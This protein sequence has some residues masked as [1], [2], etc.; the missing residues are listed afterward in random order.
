MS[1]V[2]KLYSFEIVYPFLVI[3]HP[4]YAVGKSFYNNRRQAFLDTSLCMQKTSIFISIFSPCRFP[5]EIFRFFSII[6]WL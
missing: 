2:Q 4:K 5:Y 3:E 1:L 6:R